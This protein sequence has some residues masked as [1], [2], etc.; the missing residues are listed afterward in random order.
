MASDE[1]FLMF[2]VTA[3]HFPRISKSLCI[4]S[5]VTIFY[6]PFVTMP[7]FVT[8]PT[9][10]S[11]CPMRRKPPTPHLQVA[12]SFKFLDLLVCFFEELSK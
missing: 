5:I 3:W 6:A 4:G 9:D 10:L 11:P 8:A 12:V 2:V 7:Y 1:G